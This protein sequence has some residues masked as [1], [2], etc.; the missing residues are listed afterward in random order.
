MAFTEEQI[1][2]MTDKERQK[3]VIA[4]QNFNCTGNGRYHSAAKK[5][6]N[7]VKLLEG[8]VEIQ[9]IRRSQEWLLEC[10]MEWKRR[11]ERLPYMSDDMRSAEMS[12]I[13][14][15]IAEMDIKKHLKQD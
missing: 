4:E 6:E 14:N 11:I 15:D 8:A 5:S 3:M 7:M 9:N 2:A 13:L 12:R 10:V 1:R